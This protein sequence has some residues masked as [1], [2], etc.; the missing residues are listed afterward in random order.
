MRIGR[1]AAITWNQGQISSTDAVAEQVA[2]GYAQAMGPIGIDVTPTGPLCRGRL[3]ST[4]LC[5]LTT[6]QDLFEEYEVEGEVP[7]PPS[8][9]SGA[10]A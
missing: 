5:A 9:P 2:L 7:T 10:V 3:L 6:L 4:A 1:E 8:V